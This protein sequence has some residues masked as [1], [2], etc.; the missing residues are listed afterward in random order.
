MERETWRERHGEKEMESET[1]R[2]RNGDGDM[3]EQNN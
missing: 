2:V 1:W 3:G